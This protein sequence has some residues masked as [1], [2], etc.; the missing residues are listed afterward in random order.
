MEIVPIMDESGH[1]ALTNFKNY[2]FVHLR[3]FLDNSYYLKTDHL[4]P[5]L[6]RRVGTRYLYYTRKFFIPAVR[7]Y[8]QSDYIVQNNPFAWDTMVLDIDYLFSDNYQYVDN[9]V[10]TVLRSGVG[11]AL[12]TA[13]LHTPDDISDDLFRYLRSHGYILTEGEVSLSTLQI[14]TYTFKVTY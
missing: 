3:D 13:R 14:N 5:N 12:A 6:V 4:I 11:I 2:N 9:V 7:D 8:K 10:D 1:V